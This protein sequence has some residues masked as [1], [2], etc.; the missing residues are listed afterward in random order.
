MSKE[1]KGMLETEADLQMGLCTNN[2]SHKL[3][4]FKLQC[5]YTR[6]KSIRGIQGGT[7]LANFRARAGRAGVRIT[8]SGD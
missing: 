3:T 4:H 1:E 8:H 7:K 2:L 6:S 5:R